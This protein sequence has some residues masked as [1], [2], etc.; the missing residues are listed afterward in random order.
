M[1]GFFSWF[2]SLLVEVWTEPSPSSESFVL[3]ST[4]AAGF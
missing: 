2:W 1:T 4:G 3:S